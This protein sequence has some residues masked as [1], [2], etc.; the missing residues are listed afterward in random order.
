MINKAKIYIY[1]AIKNYDK[2]SITISII[3]VADNIFSSQLCSSNKEGVCYYRL[4]QI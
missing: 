4:L 1:Q 2:Q 3:T